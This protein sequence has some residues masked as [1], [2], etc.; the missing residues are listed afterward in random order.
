MF[1]KPLKVHQED[2]KAVCG[3]H[4][5]VEGRSARRVDVRRDDQAGTREGRAGRRERKDRY[6]EKAAHLMKRIRLAFAS[7]WCQA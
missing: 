1:V 7:G 6:C 4:V 3:E 2:G 5:V